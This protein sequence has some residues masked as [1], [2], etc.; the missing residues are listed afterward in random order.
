MDISYNIMENTLDSRIAFQ[1]ADDWLLPTSV[2]LQKI[3]DEWLVP[4]TPEEEGC[5]CIAAGDVECEDFEWEESVCRVS[6]VKK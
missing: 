5:E 6:N 1:R 2:E 4:M 3:F